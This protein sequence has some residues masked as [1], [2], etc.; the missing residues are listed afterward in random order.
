[1]LKYFQRID[2]LE[3]RVLQLETE[4]DE[5]SELLCEYIDADLVMS[6]Q[7]SAQ[8]LVAALRGRQAARTHNA[9]G[10]LHESR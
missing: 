4:R 9:K 7:A 3:E 8:R 2:S 10:K 6:W 5:L 1:M